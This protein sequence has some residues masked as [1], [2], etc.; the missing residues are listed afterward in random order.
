MIDPSKI[1]ALGVVRSLDPNEQVGEQP[2]G[3][4]WCEVHVNV[5][6]EFNEEL[7]RPYHHFKKIGDVIGVPMAWPIKLVCPLL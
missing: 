3:S 6:I 5:P 7:I 4:H 2:L 1:V